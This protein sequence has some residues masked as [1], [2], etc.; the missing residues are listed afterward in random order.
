MNPQSR[1]TV[2]A[3]A[4]C[5]VVLYGILLTY[6]AFKDG[7]RW[8]VFPRLAIHTCILTALQCL[9]VFLVFHPQGTPHFDPHRRYMLG[10]PNQRGDSPDWKKTHESCIILQ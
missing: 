7:V 5:N 10:S 2:G 8:D 3:V 4:R 9:L 1:W 6:L